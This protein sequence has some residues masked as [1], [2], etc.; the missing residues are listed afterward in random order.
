MFIFLENVD[1][2]QYP[3]ISLRKIIEELPLTSQ[4]QKLSS[5]KANI[6]QRC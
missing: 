6:F 1:L 5:A 2:E 3:L 4:K